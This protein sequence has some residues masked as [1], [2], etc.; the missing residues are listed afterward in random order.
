MATV[1]ATGVVNSQCAP[2]VNWRSLGTSPDAYKSCLAVPSDG[3]RT[4]V[5]QVQSVVAWMVAE[6]L[7]PGVAGFNLADPVTGRQ[8]A[9][10]DLAWPDG[11]ETGLS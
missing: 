6:Q 7:E 3:N 4:A 8:I 9:M 2:L 1:S 5:A 11:I 10:L